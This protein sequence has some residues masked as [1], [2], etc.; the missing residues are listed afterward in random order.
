MSVFK[1]DELILKLM[2]IE[3]MVLKKI[4]GHMNIY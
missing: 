4:K 2:I 1:V 3:K